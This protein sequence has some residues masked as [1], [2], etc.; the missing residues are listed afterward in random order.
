MRAARQLFEEWLERRSNVLTF[1]RLAQVTTGHRYFDT[2]VLRIRRNET[3][4]CH[5]VDRPEDTVEVCP[6][7]AEHRH[8]LLEAISGQRSLEPGTGRAQGAGGRGGM[9]SHHRTRLKE[10]PAQRKGPD[11]GPIVCQGR[12]KK[13]TRLIFPWVMQTRD[14][15]HSNQA[16]SHW[17]AVALHAHHFEMADWA[18]NTI[19]F[20]TRVA[21]FLSFYLLIRGRMISGDDLPPCCGCTLNSKHGSSPGSRQHSSTSRQLVCGVTGT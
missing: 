2:F 11:I 5:C 6:V 8:V 18:I 4:E 7:W 16:F 10:L 1:V 3:S 21:Q 14:T 17:P 19:D 20:L 13:P 12:G 15:L 9:G